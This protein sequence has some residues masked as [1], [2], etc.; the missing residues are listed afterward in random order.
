M[1]TINDR[2]EIIIN[3]HFNGNKS[4]FGRI[5]DM[6]QGTLANYISPTK[7][8]KPP[9]DM[10]AKIVER[11][12]VDPMWLLTGRRAG[13]SGNNPA[14]T[15]VDRDRVAELE[16][17]VKILNVQI[18]EKDARISDLKEMISQLLFR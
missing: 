13:A 1:E 15:I 12:G 11:V 2:I 17:E 7:R 10:I 14:L 6:P 4:A 16:S 18:I 5:I 8:S 3:K 9:V